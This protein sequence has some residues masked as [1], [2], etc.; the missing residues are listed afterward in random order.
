MGRIVLRDSPYQLYKA[1]EELD[2]FYIILAGKVKVVD[3][4][5]RRVCQTGETIL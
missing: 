5:V 3:G 2:Y 4:F 1:G